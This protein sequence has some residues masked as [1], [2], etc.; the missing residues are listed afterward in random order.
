MRPLV[1]AETARA[2]PLVPALL[3][4]EAGAVGAALRA[5]EEGA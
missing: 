2:V 1:Y 4:A 5:S 3:G